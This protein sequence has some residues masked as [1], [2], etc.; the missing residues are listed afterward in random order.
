MESLYESA[1]CRY[2]YFMTEVATNIAETTVTRLE[3]DV[4]WESVWSA[5]E[6]TQFFEQK[7]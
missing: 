2:D 3:D 1:W 5:E 6:V 4:Y 7:S